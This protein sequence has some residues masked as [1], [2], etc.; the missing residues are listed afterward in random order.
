MGCGIPRQLGHQ[1][2]GDTSAPLLRNDVEPLQLGR[3]ALLE[4]NATEADQ[5]PS[6]QSAD[7][8]DVRAFQVG[9]PVA[10]G[11]RNRV[12]AARQLLGQRLG[13]AEYLRIS[14]ANRP[15]RHGMCRGNHA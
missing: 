10:E 4:L 1:C 7:Q 12:A 3:A 11:L 2:A 15:N 13:H 9:W 6:D 5:L 8:V 14:D